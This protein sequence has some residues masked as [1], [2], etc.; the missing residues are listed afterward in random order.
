MKGKKRAPF[1]LVPPSSTTG[2]LI[3]LILSTDL[4]NKLM[5]GGQTK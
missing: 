2:A 3:Y 5:C 4:V 1:W